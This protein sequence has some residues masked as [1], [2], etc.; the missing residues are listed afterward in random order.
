LQPG[1]N[2]AHHPAH[3]TRTE[4]HRARENTIVHHPVNTAPAKAGQSLYFRHTKN[5]YVFQILIHYQVSHTLPLLGIQQISQIPKPAA[6]LFLVLDTVR[7]G[8]NK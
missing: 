1:T 2:I 8:I 3:S 6:K 5:R 4:G 7:P